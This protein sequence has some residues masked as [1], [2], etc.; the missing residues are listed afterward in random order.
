MKCM[1]NCSAGAASHGGF[2]QRPW[3]SQQSILQKH[4]MCCI[5]KTTGLASSC[6]SLC[7]TQL[8][9]CA[10]TWCEVPSETAANHSQSDVMLGEQILRPMRFYN[11]WRKTKWF[12]FCLVWTAFTF[13]PTMAVCWPSQVN[14]RKTA[15]IWG[16]YCYS[17]GCE[18]WMIDLWLK[19]IPLAHL[20]FV[21]YCD[22]SVVKL[23]SLTSCRT[24]GANAF[25]Q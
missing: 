5:M 23:L 12:F 10:S 4:I 16:M 22:N 25:P 7:K 18:N 9:T 1:W 11:R 21:W 3:G 15:W 2:G 6:N 24:Y 19:E 14:F 20:Q 8:F 17:N 13:A